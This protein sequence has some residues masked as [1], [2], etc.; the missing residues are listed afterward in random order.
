[1]VW[2]DQEEQRG[3]W[4]G[5]IPVGGRLPPRSF[6]V[7][8]LHGIKLGLAD[9]ISESLF[10]AQRAHLEA[11]HHFRSRLYSNVG[12]AL[13]RWWFWNRTLPP[14]AAAVQEIQ[15]EASLGIFSK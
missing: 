9:G 7:A 11:G 15:E 10:Q 12:S 2:W 4:Q 5:R 8:M 13:S 1:M 6:V 3:L 14:D